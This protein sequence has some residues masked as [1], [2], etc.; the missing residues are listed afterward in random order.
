[1]W[2][3]WCR[4]A[5]ELHLQRGAD[6]G[7]GPVEQA[8]LVAVADVEGRAHLLGRAADHVAHGDHGA[9]R[10][11]ELL[12]GMADRVERLLLVEGLLRERAPVRRVGPPVAREAV[13]G[14]A[15]AVGVD[16]RPALVVG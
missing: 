16:G 3:C 11:R 13:G 4:T 12:D 14:T 10:G 7:A 8:A 9:L 1:M 6:A 15:E 2:S 5:I